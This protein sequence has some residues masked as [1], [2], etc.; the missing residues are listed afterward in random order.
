MYTIFLQVVNSHI[1]L[2]LMT[3]PKFQKAILRWY[4]M[5]RRDMPWRETKNPYKILVSE[6]MLQQTQVSRVLQK[7]QEFLSAFPTI[8]ALARAKK[9]EVLRVWSG[10]GYWRRALCLQENAKKILR[11]HKGIFPKDPEALDALP[12]IG[13][14]TARALACFAFNNDDA[15]LDT[16]IRKVFLHFFFA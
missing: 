14:Y 2:I 5:N 16:N 13:H 1:H 10:L 4:K 11:E 12:G 6:I 15:F 8:T 9:P 3:I 7:Y